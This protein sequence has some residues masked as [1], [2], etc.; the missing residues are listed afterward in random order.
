MH[1]FVYWFSNTLKPTIDRVARNV[2]NVSH[3]VLKKQQREKHTRRAHTKET[4]KTRTLTR[5]DNYLNSRQLCPEIVVKTK[6]KVY[7]LY[8]VCIQT[9]SK[10]REWTITRKLAARCCKHEPRQKIT[11]H[12][13]RVI[14]SVGQINSYTHF[15]Q[16]EWEISTFWVTNQLR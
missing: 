8:F 9:L 11:N 4:W 1:V 5:W 3:N 13:V 2:S 10:H 12:R 15:I 16:W 7:S 14:N 6:I